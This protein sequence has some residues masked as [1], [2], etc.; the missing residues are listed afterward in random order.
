[1]DNGWDQSAD[2]WLASLG[3]RGDPSREYVLDPAMLARVDRQE[4]D[5]ALDVGCGEGRFCRILKE[6]GISAV[7]IDTSVS[8]LDAAKRR[9]PSGTYH[10]ANAEQ[11]PFDNDSFDLAV[12]YV[13]L[14]DIPDF[15]AA[16]GEIA[17]VLLPGGTLLLANLS[18]MSTANGGMGWAKD[19]NGQVLYW[20]ID[21]Y[22]EEHSLRFEWSGISVVSWHRPLSA[23]MSALLAA[24]LH[25][26]FFDEPRPLGEDP[27]RQE[28]YRRM[29][30]F[31][32]MEWRLPHAGGAS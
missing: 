16:I 3:D 27:E 12:S 11:L 23:Y 1:M 31:V 28:R 2:A 15:R 9:D 14:C 24:G 19:E 10:L 4:F 7:G 25:L 6:R 22:L 13:T 20:P 21:R 8:L 29:P 26:E 32:L 17:R 30:W 18:S 5:C